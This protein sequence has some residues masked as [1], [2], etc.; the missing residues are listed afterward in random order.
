MGFFK[1]LHNKVTA[2]DGTLDLKLTNYA[3]A[4]GGNLEGSLNLSAREDF[5]AT[6]VRCEISCVEEARVIRYDYDAA[7]RRTLPRE[8]TESAVLF[9]A[10]PILSGTCH[11]TNGENRSFP[12]KMS[13]PPACRPTYQGVDRKVTWTVKGVVA[14]DGRP[15][16]T[17]HTD[18]FQVV[19]PTVQPA[20]AEQ[21][22]VREVVREVVK[23]PC[24]YCDTLFDQLETTCPNCGAKRKG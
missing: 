15:D 22:V 23:V 2:P 17:T 9:S 7:A 1:K 18:E 12:L 8:V 11:V 20:G 6:E 21:V 16:A 13:I 4:L 24:R 10:K 14:V 19:Q 3:V 5:D